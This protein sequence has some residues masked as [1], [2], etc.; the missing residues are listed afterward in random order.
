M[1]LMTFLLSHDQEVTPSVVN[2]RLG[3]TSFRREEK[4]GNEKTERYSSGSRE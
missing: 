2:R 3:D 1:K 4:S